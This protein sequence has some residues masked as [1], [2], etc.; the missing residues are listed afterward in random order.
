MACDDSPG[1]QGISHTA[2]P[3]EWHQ[4]KNNVSWFHCCVDPAA[5]I[6]IRHNPNSLAMPFLNTPTPICHQLNPNPNP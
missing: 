5:N 3:H 2:L 4:N 1:R 6:N